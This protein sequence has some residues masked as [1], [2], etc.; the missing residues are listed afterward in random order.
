SPSRRLAESLQAMTAALGTGY[1]YRAIAPQRSAKHCCGTWWASGAEALERLCRY[2]ARP[3]FAHARLAWTDDD[4]I[5]YRLKRPWRDGRTHLVL[6]PVAFLR[7]LN[8][9]ILEKGKLVFEGIKSGALKALKRLEELWGKLRELFPRFAGFT[10]ERKRGLILI[11][12]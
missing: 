10:Y 1:P 3:A 12:A 2:G 8:G 6:E 5:S 4:R 9:L 7:R 11:F